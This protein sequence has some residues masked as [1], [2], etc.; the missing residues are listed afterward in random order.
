MTKKDGSSGC[1]CTQTLLEWEAW[2]L[3]WYQVGAG[4]S[5]N[6]WVKVH[7]GS[8]C[9]SDNHYF[10]QMSNAD[11]SMEGHVQSLAKEKEL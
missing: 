4:I 1:H 3:V 8:K 11:H 7:E 9:R 2:Q 10:L 5:V 6:G